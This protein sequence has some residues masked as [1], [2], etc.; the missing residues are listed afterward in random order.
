MR[1]KN[2]PKQRGFRP[3][4]QTSGCPEDSAAV[5]SAAAGFAGLT[6]A[7]VGRKRRYSQHLASFPT[8]TAVPSSAKSATTGKAFTRRCS[9]ALTQP[10]KRAFLTASEGAAVLPRC[11]CLEDPVHDTIQKQQRRCP[12][13]SLPL[14][15][16]L[17]LLFPYTM[18]YQPTAREAA[19][20]A[21]AAGAKGRTR[22]KTCERKDALCSSE[23]SRQKGEQQWQEGQQRPPSIVAYTAT[24]VLEDVQTFCE[25][26]VYIESLPHEIHLRTK[27]IKKQPQRKRQPHRFTSLAIALTW[28]QKQLH[29]EGAILPAAAGCLCRSYT[30][31]YDGVQEKATAVG[32]AEATW[33]A[34]SRR[35]AKGATRT[36]PAAPLCISAAA[37]EASTREAH[38]A[39]QLFSVL[40]R[41]REAHKA[42]AAAGEGKLCAKHAQNPAAAA[43][44][45]AAAWVTAAAEIPRTLQCTR[46]SSSSGHAELQRV[47]AVGCCCCPVGSPWVSL[48][49][50]RS[51]RLASHPSVRLYD[52][53]L[54]AA[55]K[56]RLFTAA[57]TSPEPLQQ[58]MEAS[59]LVACIEQ[60]SSA[61][62]L[63]AAAAVA[64]VADIA[65][66]CAAAAVREFV[67]SVPLHPRSSSTSTSTSTS[68][69]AS[70]STSTSTSTSSSRRV[71]TWISAPNPFAAAAKTREH[72]TSRHNPAQLPPVSLAFLI[73]LPELELLSNSCSAAAAAAA[74]AAARAW[75]SG[76]PAVVPLVAGRVF[77]SAPAKACLLKK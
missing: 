27:H 30:H 57:D 62:P 67:E 44:E 50:W 42:A 32:T 11:I 28:L 68:T 52:V 76:A 65:I 10:S 15:L 38:A 6:S 26:Q 35:A 60:N 21:A 33:E 41:V 25:Q 71:A 20:A 74:A 51:F 53:L 9:D 12:L 73:V 22:K 18:P 45:A 37:L 56:R 66:Q 2:A 69:S 75:A 13:P 14:R 39:L 8:T 19:A 55:A 54:L 43:T 7:S 77:Y 47:A 16:P 5:A 34:A 3:Y 63:P 23:G 4:L 29:G 36:T 31:M 1:E 59:A 48:S 64:A 61:A 40:R 24:L 72:S 46:S 58:L 49:A 70:T 17:K